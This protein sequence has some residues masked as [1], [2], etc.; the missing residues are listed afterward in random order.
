MFLR[1][2]RLDD[3][4][5]EREF[6]AFY[7]ANP[8]FLSAGMDC[9]LI[10]EPKIDPKSKKIEPPEEEQLENIRKLLPESAKCKSVRFNYLAKRRRILNNW[11]LGQKTPNLPKLCLPEKRV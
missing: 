10:V 11:H 4:Y 8:N 7:E 6:N 9:E 1:C 5:C 2:L 3:L